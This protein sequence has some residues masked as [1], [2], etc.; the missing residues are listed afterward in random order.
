[1]PRLVHSQAIE[2]EDTN[3]DARGTM[4]DFF[5]SW[6][7][8]IGCCLLVLAL[9]LTAVWVRSI[10]IQ[11]TLMLFIGSRNIIISVAAGSASFSSKIDDLEP[12]EPFVFQHRFIVRPITPENGN[13]VHA[14][15]VIGKPFYLAFW[16]L[17]V[18]LTISS[19]ILLCR[20]TRKTY[21]PPIP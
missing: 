20:P 14:S 21:G 15:E 18:P 5:T 3:A 4:R 8:K 19:A 2:R 13:G 17:V 1:M 9:L 11:D 10:G 7:R 16:V 12:D 6:Q